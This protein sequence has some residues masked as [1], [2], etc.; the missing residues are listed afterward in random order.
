MIPGAV[1]KEMPAQI[2]PKHL[3]AKIQSLELGKDE[4]RILDMVRKGQQMAAREAFYAGKKAGTI[5]T[6]EEWEQWLVDKEE[7]TIARQRVAKAKDII[8]EAFKQAKYMRPIARDFITS[9]K[10]KLDIKTP[11][12]KTLNE[13]NRIADF[14]KQHPEHDMPQAVIDKLNRLSKRPI[15]DMTVEELE[16]VATEVQAHVRQSNLINKMIIRGRLQEAEE[17]VG[18]AVE[19][20]RTKA[21][22]TKYDPNEI[23]SDDFE[24]RAGTLRQ[25]AGVKSYNAE[26]ISEILDHKGDNTIHDIMYKGID[27]GTD[28]MLSYQHGAHDYLKTELNNAGIKDL[29]TWSRAIGGKKAKPIEVHISKGRKIKMTKAERVAFI[30]H[31]FNEKNVKHLIEGGFA[32][33]H[34]KTR[35]FRNLSK[36]DLVTVIRGATPEELKLVRIFQNAINNMGNELNKTSMSLYGREIFT[37][38]NYWRI[39]TN[40]LDRHI[41]A[42]K[43][44]SFGH[45]TLEGMGFLKE[46]RNAQNAIVIEDAFTTLYKHIKQTSAFNGLA[47]PLRNAKMLLY[48]KGFRNSVATVRGGHYWRALQNYLKDV[49]G[50]VISTS[51]IEKIA[52]KFVNKIDLA[53]LG[54]NPFVMLK[55]PV[56]YIMAATEMPAK[57]LL[58]AA[59]TRPDFDEIAKWSPQLRDRLEGNVTRELGE[60]GQ[61]GTVR[62]F[63]TG[64]SPVSHGL[65]AGIRTF[66]L[67]TIG[68][69]WNAAKFEIAEK[70]PNLQGNE[71]MLKVKERAEEVIRKTQPTFAIKDRSEI[72]RDRSLFVRLATKYTSQRNKNYMQL[73]RAWEKYATSDK[74]PKA[75]AELLSRW[76][77]I[78]IANAVA[79]EGI[80]ELRNLAYKR[81][82]TPLTFALNAIGTAMGNMYV[83]GDLFKSIASKYEKGT[84]GYDLNNPFSSAVQ[85]IIDAIGETGRAITQVVTEERY[86][87]GKQ[88]DELK[89]KTTAMRALDKGLTGIGMFTGIPYRTLRSMVEGGYRWIKPE[90]EEKENKK[91][92]MTTQRI[93]DLSTGKR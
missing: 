50:D 5:K 43:T 80:N 36:E 21:P 6:D 34:N 8:N 26:L 67:Q 46:R 47:E 51:D 24:K 66:D 85:D 52:T 63:F 60:L 71:Y 59:V 23:S 88:K 44:R 87:S 62:K 12:S 54:M 68:R 75:K 35:I 22:G 90:K 81:K 55:Q 18:K 1:E 15:K 25:L 49:E 83:V 32:F 56:S 61:V 30:L 29:E 40:E 77:T 27:E 72:G 93:I 16:D 79:I 14:M 74:T 78:V 31:A 48:D 38:P 28:K 2:K 11:T 69:V 33:E 86:K 73:R 4:G 13:L 41:D 84:F 70:F 92:S 20:I 39:Q 9:L 58:R 7:S 10:N 42:L 3:T 76:A 19:N 91:P 57:Y 89:W 82:A 45:K 65:M 53:V 64:K 17:V 37:E